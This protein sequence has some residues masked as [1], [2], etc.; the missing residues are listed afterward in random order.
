MR[1]AKRFGAFHPPWMDAS[2]TTDREAKPRSILLD[3][4]FRRFWIGQSISIVGSSIGNFAFALVAVVVLGA[5]PGQ[6]GL[7]FALGRIPPILLGLFAGDWV[8]RVPR[9]R[10]LIAI[11]IAAALVVGSV[12]LLYALDSLSIGWLYASSLMFGVIDS[13]DDPAWNAFLP[14]LVD[15]DRLV[16][17]NSKMMLS[18]SSSGIFGPVLA[19]VLVELITAPVTMVVDATSFIVSAL[20]LTRVHVT[21]HIEPGAAEAETL[22]KRIRAGLR[23]AFLDPMQRAVTAPRVLLGFVDA[24]ALAVYVLYVLREVELSAGALGVI[25]M[26]GSVGFLSGSFVAGRIERRLGAGWAAVLGL[27]LVGLSPFTMVLARAEYPL[28]LNLFFLGL[29]GILGGFGG[30]I[31]YVMLSSIRQ[32]ITPTEMLG[33]VYASVGVL[34]GVM[35]VAGAFTG[36]LLGER[37]GLRPT[38]FVVACGY[39][40][41]LWLSLV[42]PLPRAT[43]RIEES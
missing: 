14:S 17:A 24:M 38:I 1:L 3:N 15:K 27:G 7:I 28:A 37:I 10:L 33:R 23:T 25:F 13:L 29:P 34:W 2:S 43:T 4:E 30:M 22:V 6:M 39:T 19:G 16:D 5:S 8:D 26:F 12:P 42:S 31:Q 32:A 9:R 11:D 36:G 40:V 18:F 41:P 35:T 21:E 20:I